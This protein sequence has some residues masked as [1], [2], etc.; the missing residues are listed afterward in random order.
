MYLALA[1]LFFIQMTLADS[2]RLFGA[3][4]DLGAMFVIFIAVF[5]GPWTAL[6]AGAVFGALKDIYSL[7][8]FGAGTIALGATG[9]IAGLLSPKFFR[10]SR[11]IQVS[12]VFVFT[13]LYFFIHYL[14]ALACGGATDAR[15]REHLLLSFMP[16]CLYTALLSMAAFPF[17]IN[18]FGLK[19]NPEYL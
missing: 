16:T 17:L 5:F 9:F 15:F 1:A 13:L 10:E 14:L 8:I 3:R 4:P 7:D 2:V 18:R 11:V 12:I 6:E 19:E